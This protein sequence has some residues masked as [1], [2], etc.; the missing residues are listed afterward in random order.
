MNKKSI[1]LTFTAILASILVLNLAS[2]YYYPPH[3]DYGSDYS[4][5]YGGYGS[6]GGNSYSQSS[7]YTNQQSSM[8]YYPWGNERVT[9]YVNQ[10]TIVQRAYNPPMYY[11][12]YFNTYTTP[13]YYAP[14]YDYNQGY[15][16]WR[17]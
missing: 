17:Y 5:G 15:Y 12:R 16:N 1:L 6:Y 8:N 9:T 13:Y 2:A 10:R 11:P 14:R 3:P 7:Y 4:Y